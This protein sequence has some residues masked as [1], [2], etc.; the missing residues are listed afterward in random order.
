M[1]ARLFSSSLAWLA[2]VAL[3]VCAAAA[4]IDDTFILASNLLNKLMVLFVVLAVVVFFWGLIK[5]LAGLDSSESKSEGLQLMMYGV[6]AIFVMVS[7][8]GIIAL[9]QNTF[10]VGGGTVPKLPTIIP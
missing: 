6:I 4:S 2:A 3:P 8:W 9:L 1:R 7:L 10:K 5:Y